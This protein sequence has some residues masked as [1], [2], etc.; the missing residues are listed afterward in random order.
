MWPATS[1]FRPPSRLQDLRWSSPPAR[2]IAGAQRSGGP[3]GP[4]HRT[5]HRHQNPRVPADRCHP[6]GGR[7]RPGYPYAGGI[8][9]GP[10]CGR[11]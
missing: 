11:R 7:G 1:E 6:D 10:T 8:R 9:Q 4:D 2:R 5:P 3:D